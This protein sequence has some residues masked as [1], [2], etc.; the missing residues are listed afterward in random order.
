[1]GAEAVDIEAPGPDSF[2][3]AQVI[4]CRLGRLHV[5]AHADEDEL[6][7]FATIR[8]DKV[9]TPARLAVE[10]LERVAHR[11]L[12][13]LVIPALRD[14]PFP[15]RILVLDHAGHY[16]VGRIHE[17]YQLLF[18]LAD[19]FLHEIQFGEANAFDG[20]RRQEAVLDIH[21]GSLRTFSRAA[22]DQAKVSR[23]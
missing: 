2:F 4:D 10:F 14:F 5:T 18:W 13:L 16:R 8:I 12:A 17:I 15:V 9:I 3:V 20:V 21:E 23:L 1:E 7:V 11:R 19:V 6:R 22:A